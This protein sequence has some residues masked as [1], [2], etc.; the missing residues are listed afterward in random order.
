MTDLESKIFDAFANRGQYD[1]SS[2]T[3]QKQSE[4]EAISYLEVSGQIV[5]ETRTI[6]YVVGRTV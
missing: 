4:L 2:D 6:G 1:L 3:M 5:I